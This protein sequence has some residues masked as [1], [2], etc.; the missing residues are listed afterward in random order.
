MKFKFLEVSRK[1]HIDCKRLSMI[2]KIFPISLDILEIPRSS[3]NVVRWDPRILPEFLP[4]FTRFGV[5][6]FV[7]L[8]FEL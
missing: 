5:G 3:K 4:N 1:F 7:L 2:S 8:E 6:S